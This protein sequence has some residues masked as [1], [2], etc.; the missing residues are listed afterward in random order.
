MNLFKLPFLKKLDN[1]LLLNH[2]KIWISKVHYIA[3]YGFCLWILSA[4]L[5]LIIP[6]NLKSTEDLGLWYFIFSIISF[7]LFCFWVYRIV[8]FNNEKKYGIKKFSDA[9]LNLF[10]TAVCAA[11]FILTPLPFSVT[12]NNRV[13]NFVND[14]ELI[15]DINQLNRAE[16]YMI[17]NSYNYNS[18]YDSIEKVNKYD[19]RIFQNFDANTPW[20][21]KNDSLKHPTLLTFNQ[22]KKEYKQRT[23]E[24]EIKS[25]IKSNYQ[26]QKKYGVVVISEQDFVNEVYQRYVNLVSKSPITETGYNYNTNNY[27]HLEKCITNI[28]QA[29]FE[30]LFIF[31]SEFL[32][33]IM[34]SILYSTLLILLFK[35]VNWQQYLITIVTLI[36]LPILL[37]IFSQLI[38]YF[39]NGYR[40]KQ[41]SYVM[42]ISL[43]FFICLGFTLKSSFEKK[44]F[45]AFQ[46]IC[47][48]LVF[49]TLPFF[50]L[51]FL[52]VLKE[53]FG[54]FGEYNNYASALSYEEMPSETYDNSYYQSAEY[55]YNEMMRDYW[56][57]Q[58]D[59]WFFGLMFGSIIIFILVIFPLMQQL[60]IKQLALPRKK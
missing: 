43:V 17:S 35:L 39:E 45:N 47:N 10:L 48:Q 58:Y 41:N 9:Y 53:V 29:K 59:Y 51:I 38:P 16:A 23:N 33:F 5:G 34:Y 3:F 24:S 42:S 37:F 30:T 20:V 26:I 25:L 11:F 1:Y 8:I 49:I 50:P 44:Q 2:P 19:F 31:K 18:F 55:F 36:L 54:V 12:Y 52:N 56:Q 28:S 7:V 60:F 13:A 27:Y 22:L 14:D 6:L 4:F 15:S 46:N 57:K 40:I 32:I 21:L